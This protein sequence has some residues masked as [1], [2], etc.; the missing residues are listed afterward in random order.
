M[1]ETK[2]YH[3]HAQVKK[4]VDRLAVILRDDMGLEPGEQVE[5]AINLLLRYSNSFSFEGSEGLSPVD[6]L[7]GLL[8]INKKKN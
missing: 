3:D 2:N 6:K 4:A 1:T 7:I 5:A 8:S